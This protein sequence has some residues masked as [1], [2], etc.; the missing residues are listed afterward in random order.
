MRWRSDGPEPA[1]MPDARVDPLDLLSTMNYAVWPD[2]AL[3]ARAAAGMPTRCDPAVY[4]CR[5][6]GRCR[7]CGAEPQ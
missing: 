4:R 5:L 7:L 2:A 3:A 6:T 1:D